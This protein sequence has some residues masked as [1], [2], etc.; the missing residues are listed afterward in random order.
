MGN[1][2]RHACISQLFKTSRH[3]KAKVIVSS[4]YIHDLSNSAIQNLDYTLIFKSFNKETLMVLFKALDLSIEFETFEIYI[5]MLQLNPLI[6]YVDSR[7]NT[8]K[9]VFYERYL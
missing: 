2:L 6:L 4:K 9:F 8:Y 1:D 7:D 3:Y 5:R